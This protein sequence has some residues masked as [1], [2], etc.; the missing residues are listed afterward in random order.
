[1]DVTTVEDGLLRVDIIDAQRGRVRRTDLTTMRPD[2]GPGVRA[3]NTLT[4]P[5]GTNERQLAV[6]PER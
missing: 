1:M 2:P 4:W 6:E 5:R 3:W